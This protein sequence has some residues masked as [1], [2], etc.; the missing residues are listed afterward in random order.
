MDGV[1]LDELAD[2]VDA[3]GACVKLRSRKIWILGGHALL[4][5]RADTEDLDSGILPTETLFPED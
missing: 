1:G 3:V 4:R 5:R 2:E